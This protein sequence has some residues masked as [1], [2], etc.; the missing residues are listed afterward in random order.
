MILQQ[1]ALNEQRELEC[2][3]LSYA[4][5]S[6]EDK[7]CTVLYSKSVICGSSITLGRMMSVPPQ[8]FDVVPIQFHKPTPRPRLHQINQ[9]L[10]CC[11]NNYKELL[12]SHLANFGGNQFER[13]TL[14]H[15]YI[16]T[17]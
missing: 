6:D 9:S 1:G 7:R 12:L 2:G 11:I 15:F 16:Y 8:R 14:I 5:K 3:L 13:L 10:S 17:R 4:D